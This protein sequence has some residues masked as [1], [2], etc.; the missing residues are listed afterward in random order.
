MSTIYL[1]G[2]MGS[3]KSTVGKLLG[4]RLGIDFYDLDEEIE[5][6]TKQ[7]IPEIFQKV[8]EEGFRRYE[9]ELLKNISSSKPKIIATG[10]GVVEKQ[11]NRIFMKEN[12]IV[13]YLH[14]EFKS[15]E[16]RLENDENRP[17][18][19]KSF[20]GKKALYIRRLTLYEDCAHKKIHTDQLSP[21]TIAEKISRIM[22]EEYWIE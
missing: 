8:G 19:S 10:G 22:R 9:S 1:V 14:T 11:A 17:L 21:N 16:K 3:G 2:F 15:I 4:E 13:I 12:G 6:M 20:E 18:W 7:S 5:K